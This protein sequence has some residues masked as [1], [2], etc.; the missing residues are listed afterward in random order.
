LSMGVLV[1]LCMDGD[2]CQVDAMASLQDWGA[3]STN[4]ISTTDSSRCQ[5]DMCHLV[6]K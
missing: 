2:E 3:T 5:G 1:N 4:V 6:L